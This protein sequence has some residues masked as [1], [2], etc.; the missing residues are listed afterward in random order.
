M[1]AAG[2]EG[3]Y[4]AGMC[5]IAGIVA[6]AGE[7]E[8]GEGDLRR[9]SAAIAH[10]GPDGEGMALVRSATGAVAGLVHRRLAVLD[11]NPRSNQ[12]FSAEHGGRR[13]HLVYNGEIYNYRELRKRLEGELPD[14]RWRTTGDTEVLLAAYFAWGEACA[15][16]LVG[17]FA[18]AIF[19]EVDGSLL[20]GRDVMGQK[21]LFVAVAPETG[22]GI[23]A[24][25][26]ASELGAVA[27][28]PW[29]DC[30]VDE[31]ALGMYLAF[32]YV[33]AP[34]TIYRGVRK[35]ATKM[36]TR[37]RPPGPTR[38]RAVRPEL[39]APGG[40]GTVPE[41]RRL[42]ERAVSSQLVSDVPLGCFLSGGIDSSVV[43]LCAQRELRKVGGCLDTFT[44]KFD[45]PR[46]DESPF[47]AEVARHLGTRHTEFAV[48]PDAAAD[49]PGLAASYG[50][51]F[52]DSS[53]LP[54][55]YLSRET[56]R[57]VKV[58][59]AGDGGDELFCGY[60]RYR[61]MLAAE[62][63]GSVA[64][65]AN[66]LLDGPRLAGHHPKSLKARLGRFLAAADLP[67]PL[68]YEAYMRVFPPGL[69]GAPPLSGRIGTQP[70]LAGD[71]V[72]MAMS[73][74]RGTYLPDDLLAKVDRASM[75]VGLEVRAPF[76]DHQL[77]AFA[78]GL[79]RS[80]LL[81]G[82]KKG[83]LRRAFSAELPAAVFKRRKM[84]FAVP[85]GEWFRSSL[86]EMLRSV[87]LDPSGFAAGRF[88]RQAVA[89]LVEQHEAA[90]ADHSQ[91]LFALLMLEL[92]WKGRR[93]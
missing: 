66:S 90:E 63:F 50:E 22:G 56:R 25:A 85:I 51:P 57:H 88:G 18:F 60:D 30:E 84:G 77:V 14:F 28:V 91:R 52:G 10:R 11:P 54:T 78:A 75:R 72:T 12:P 76:M 5:G 3:S 48:N 36:T 21:P 89:G 6:F 33:P 81:R 9:M 38:Q 71:V 32:G 13:A 61:A 17:M 47:A 42:V 64:G 27:T 4:P 65:L 58:A 68:R 2:A 43:A 31:A 16:H 59:L 67:A 44:A 35:H 19:D 23:G 87:V 74:D 73:V 55:Y 24:V 41:A 8:P 1:R 37:Y 46:Y 7:R 29:A 39:V 83:V 45:D 69:L 53:C 70:F 40:G 86:R 15:D 79:P 82:G 20:L 80:E 92:W 34:A 26:F 93:T 49:L 62:K